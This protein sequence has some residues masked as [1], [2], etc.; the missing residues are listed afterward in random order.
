MYLPRQ[1]AGEVTEG[2]NSQM[3]SPGGLKKGWLKRDLKRELRQ[4]VLKLS[5]SDVMNRHAVCW[6]GGFQC[7]GLCTS[8][9]SGRQCQ[10]PMLA[11]YRNLGGI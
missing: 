9:L 1:L 11:W 6:A 7:Q 8:P 10:T 4:T 5:D 3:F 2:Y